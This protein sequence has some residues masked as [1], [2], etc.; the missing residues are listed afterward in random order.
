MTKVIVPEKTFKNIL[1]TSIPF[2]HEEPPKENKYHNKENKVP[3]CQGTIHIVQQTLPQDYGALATAGEAI[4]GSEWPL[5]KPCQSSF[6]FKCTQFWWSLNGSPEGFWIFL[7]QPDV[8]DQHWKDFAIV[9]HLVRCRRKW[10]YPVMNIQGLHL[11]A[12]LKG[13]KILSLAVLLGWCC[14]QLQPSETK[15]VFPSTKESSSNTLGTNERFCRSTV[16]R[17]YSLFHIELEN[18]H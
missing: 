11:G 9:A 16:A 6:F 1:D 2:S 5:P 8:L 7:D 14:L 3:Q 13:R 18:T 15:Q 4:C 12:P 10:R 17:F